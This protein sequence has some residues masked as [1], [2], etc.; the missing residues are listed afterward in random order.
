MNWTDQSQSVYQV[1]VS[2]EAVAAPGVTPVSLKLR[3]EL[4]LAAENAA[5]M[6][7]LVANLRNLAVETSSGQTGHSAQLIEELQQPWG[8]ELNQG[9]LERLHMRGSVSPFSTSIATT[10]AAA[11]QYRVASGTSW[12]TEETD[13]SGQY[14]VLYTLGASASHVTKTKKSYQGVRLPSVM[15]MASTM[16]L[17][18]RI[19]SSS[20]AL[21]IDQGRLMHVRLREELEVA[22]TTVSPLRSRTDIELTQRSVEKSAGVSSW[23][24]LL[25][26]TVPVTPGRAV[27]TSQPKPELDETRI[28]N[29]TFDTALSELQKDSAPSSH[30]HGADNLDANDSEQ[31]LRERSRAFSAMV[32][33]L[34]SRPADIE[35]A[36]TTIGSRSPACK[37]LLDALGSAGTPAAQQALAK[38]A[39]TA[40]LNLEVRKQAAFALTRTPHPTPDSVQ[41]LMKNMDDK[42]L[43]SYAIYGLGTYARRLRELGEV[44]LSNQASEA[45]L[46]QLESSKESNRVDV[47]RGIANSGYAPALSRV[48]PLLLDADPS[49][50]T[51]AAEALRLMPGPDVD[52]LIAAHMGADENQNVR[53]AALNAAGLREP[54]DQLVAAVVD[55]VENA[56]DSQSRGKAVRLIERWL[57][58]RPELRGHLQRVA[59]SDSRDG[60]RKLAQAAVSPG[61]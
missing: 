5:P 54:N 52:F 37:P 33:I 14:S 26:S 3:G 41:V 22:L 48:R 29:Y 27:T 31:K 59:W 2:S 34:R 23:Q 38:L 47:L 36:V 56:P 40:K 15:P 39:Q 1:E 13:A 30:G 20:G 6:T 49:T 7:R 57:P 35:R 45:L 9:R 61:K 18:P 17:T 44:A 50:R 58:K 12:T 51:A 55:T 28:G 24:Q 16:D 53:L 19:V 4:T 21:H 42:V 25:A 46:T 43:R 11:L 32:A 10:L 8:F 60:V